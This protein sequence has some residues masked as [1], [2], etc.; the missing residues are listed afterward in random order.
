MAKYLDQ[1]G[2]KQLVD[3]LKTVHSALNTKINSEIVARENFATDATSSI[4][5]L[6]TKIDDATADMIQTIALSGTTLSITSGAGITDTYQIQDTTY[7]LVTTVKAGLMSSSDKSKLNNLASITSAGSNITISSGKISATDTTYSDATTSK[8]GLMSASDKSKLNGIAANANNYT[9]PTATSST[10]G[11]VKVGSGISVSN[12][13]ISVPTV[14]SSA[15]GLMTSSDKKKLDSLA[16]ITTAGN[17]VTISGGTISAGGTYSLPTASTSTKG[18]VKIGNGLSMSG[19]TLNV[20]VSGVDDLETWNAANLY[21]RPAV[22]GSA[23]ST[24]NGAIWYVSDSGTSSDSSDVLVF[25]TTA[26]TVD[27]AV[28]FA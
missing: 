25:G 14:T 5:A 6:D 3:N 28:W 23:P 7:D 18:G 24:V 1:N 15:N 8:S 9:L 13:T 16:S 11:G 27:G 19:D 26:S 4:S 20:T 2:A 10:L 17:N 22:L 21:L 12:G